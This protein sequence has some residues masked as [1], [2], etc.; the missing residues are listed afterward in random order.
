MLIKQSDTNMLRIKNQIAQQESIR[1]QLVA[2]IE[3][4]RSSFE[5]SSELI[6]AER[7]L[8]LSLKKE[9]N[10]KSELISIDYD[11]EDHSENLNRIGSATVDI[12]RLEF[13]LNRSDMID[14]SS[15]CYY[16][17]LCSCRDRVLATH[18]LERRTNDDKIVFKDM[19][20]AFSQLDQ[21]FEIIVELFLLRL[22]YDTQERSPSGMKVSLFLFQP[23]N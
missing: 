12:R 17:C 22:P 11:N 4:C 20:M 3:I 5:C 18:A 8:L 16:V 14:T 15:K 2:A 7:L 9:S 1:E 13:P 6:E 23:T 19:K 10:A 21:Q